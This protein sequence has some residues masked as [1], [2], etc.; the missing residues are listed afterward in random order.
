MEVNGAL[1]NAIDLKRRFWAAPEVMPRL[2][3]ASGR[4]GFQ[5][6]TGEVRFRKIEIKELPP[7]KP[8]R[9]TPE[10]AKVDE[11]WLK[12]VAGL[13]PGEQVKAV[14]QKLR[15]LNPS[16]DGKMT[17]TVEGSVVTGL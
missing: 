6:H 16:F 1:V 12:S 5:K 9:A 7:T 13:S 17:P 11:A 4:L 10:A 8:G 3:Q 2:K 14:A 15:D